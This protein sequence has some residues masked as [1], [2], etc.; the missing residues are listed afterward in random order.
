M[1]EDEKY[2]M[3]VIES[4]PPFVDGYKEM[5]NRLGL[6][7]QKKDK[8][9]ADDLDEGLALAEQL[10][11]FRRNMG[12]LR[13]QA[14][15]ILHS[16]GVLKER[17][18]AAIETLV[19]VK[20]MSRADADSR[21]AN[22]RSQMVGAPDAQDHISKEQAN[23]GGF[24]IRVENMLNDFVRWL[25]LSDKER[26]DDPEV[27]VAMQETLNS[28]FAEITTIKAWAGNQVYKQPA[29]GAQ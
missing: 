15:I 10:N 25:C 9:R 29:E 2:V 7:M 28:C 19:E 16:A 22:L 8:E 11:G 5:M 4:I 12:T 6:W 1:I 27:A 23:L 17:A 20:H 21:I 3:A 18:V 26:H 14:T 24:A 13:H